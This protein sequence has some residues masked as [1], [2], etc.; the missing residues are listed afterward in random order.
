MTGSLGNG[1]LRKLEVTEV[2]VVSGDTSTEFVDSEDEGT[3]R[4]HSLQ[5]AFRTCNKFK[6]GL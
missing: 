4:H 2:I 5:S 3:T 1:V 6:D